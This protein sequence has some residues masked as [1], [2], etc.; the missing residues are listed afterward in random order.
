MAKRF[1]LF[2]VAAGL[3]AVLMVRLDFL[4]EKVFVTG[5]ENSRDVSIAE[6]GL[7]FS[8]LMNAKVIT[9]F[10]GNDHR[11]VLPQV[12]QV[13]VEKAAFDQANDFS[14][15]QKIAVK[16]RISLLKALFHTP[17][18]HAVLTQVRLWNRAH[19]IAAVRDNRKKSRRVRVNLWKAF[20]PGPLNLPLPSS[21]Y[22][23]E[24]YGFFNRSMRISTLSSRPRVKSFSSKVKYWSGSGI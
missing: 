16:K 10:P 23:P 20:E 13:L 19:L 17:A 2:F 11:L 24:S 15:E 9:P 6:D 21:Q 12:D 5:E 14:K 4:H 7:L 1:I 18:G 22:V 3:I 8:Q